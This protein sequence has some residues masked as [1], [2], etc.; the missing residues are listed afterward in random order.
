MRSSFKL[1]KYYKTYFAK[2]ACTSSGIKEGCGDIRGMIVAVFISWQITGGFTLGNKDLLMY[3]L[4]VRKSSTN[5][6]L[7]PYPKLP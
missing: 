1:K 5:C 4:T 6:T 3:W 2:L 7:Y